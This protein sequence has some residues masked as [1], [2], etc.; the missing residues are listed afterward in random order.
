[1]PAL[2]PEDVDRVAA[3]AHLELTDEERALFTRQLAE[4][5]AY[6]EQVREVDT[7]GVPPTTHVL[8]PHTVFRPDELR[9]GLT[10]ETALAGAPVAA[11]EAGLFKVPRVFGG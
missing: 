5:L 10:R 6:A 3:L 4:I 1:M 2:T 7:T 9:P 11:R 8:T